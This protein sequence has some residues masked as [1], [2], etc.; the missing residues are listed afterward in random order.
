[1]DRDSIK[2]MCSCIDCNVAIYDENLYPNIPQGEVY[3][4]IIADDEDITIYR[5]PNCKSKM[6]TR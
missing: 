6:Y 2:V 5:C 3:Q 4:D 1:M